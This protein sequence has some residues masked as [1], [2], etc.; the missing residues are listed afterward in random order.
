MRCRDHEAVA[1]ALG[2][3]LLE[4][5][6]DLLRA[7][8]DRV[9]NAAAAY[10]RAATDARVRSKRSVSQ[11]DGRNVPVSKHNKSGP[12]DSIR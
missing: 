1:G 12:A 7:A 3:P 10:A 8:D 4:A 6:G 5:I 2:E 11:T 9:F